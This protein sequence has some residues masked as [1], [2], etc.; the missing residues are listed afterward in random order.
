[1]STP[2]DKDQ[3]L[4]YDLCNRLQKVTKPFL[5]Q[6]KCLGSSMLTYGAL[7]VNRGLR[8]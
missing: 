3:I 8:R 2:L 7:P 6:L 1:M 4:V 5:S